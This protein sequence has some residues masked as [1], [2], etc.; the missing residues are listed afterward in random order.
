MS[1]SK[2]EILRVRTASPAF[3]ADRNDESV[4]ERSPLF[5]SAILLQSGKQARNHAS[6]PPTSRSGIGRC[7]DSGAVRSKQKPAQGRLLSRDA[8]VEETGE[9]LIVQIP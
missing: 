8:G 4:V 9:L 5:G 7:G 2:S 1:R 6:L 3:A